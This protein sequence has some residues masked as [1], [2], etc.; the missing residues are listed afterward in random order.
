MLQRIQTVYLLLASVA[1]ILLFFVPLANYYNQDLGNYKL[2]IS[3][4]KCMDPDP[5]HIFGTWYTLPLLFLTVISIILDLSAIF[6]FRKR[7]LQMRFA[8]FSG[9]LMIVLV[10]VVFFFYAT[11]ISEITRIEPEYSLFGMMLPLASLVFVI[12]ANYAIRKDEALVKS[13]DRLR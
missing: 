7:W 9:L 2:Y 10:M 12:L 5:K 3:S 4:V 11:K 13:A 8:A 1:C 6:F